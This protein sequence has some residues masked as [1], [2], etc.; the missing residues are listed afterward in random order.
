[1]KRD[2][3][4]SNNFAEATEGDLRRNVSQKKDFYPMQILLSLVIIGSVIE[5]MTDVNSNPALY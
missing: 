2:F 4:R 3:L 5:K 1:M